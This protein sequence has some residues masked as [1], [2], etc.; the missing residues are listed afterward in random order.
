MNSTLE[1]SDAI[2]TSTVESGC[3]FATFAEACATIEGYAG[4]TNS[5]IILGKTK[6][7]PDN[8]YKQVLFVCEKQGKYAG[9]NDAYT[10]KCIGCPFAISVY[11]RKRDKEFAIIKSC[12][13]HNHDPCSDATKFS[14]VMRKLDQNDLGLIEKLHNDGLR[15]K[16]IFSV[17][18]S[19]STKYIH[20]PDVYD[21]ISRQRQ[22]KLQG[23]S[24]IEMLLKNLHEDENIIGDIALKNAFNDERNQDGKFMQAI[25]WAYRNAFSEF[26]VGKDVL[27]I[28]ATYKTNRFSMPLVAICSVD[29]FG[30]TYPL[31]FALVYS[32]TQEFY[33]WVLQQLSKALIIV[34]GS[35]QVATI[36]TDRELALMIAISKV[37]PHT[38]HQLCTW[39]IFKNIKNKLRREVEID[40]FIKDVQKLTYSD[41]SEGEAEK[42]ITALW[43]KYPRAKIYMSET[44]MPYKKSWLA[45]Y[46][47]GNIN[48]DLRSSQRVESLHS[49]LKG[50]KN[51]IIPNKHRHD[52]ANMGLE[53]LKSVCSRFAFESF[54]KQQAELAKSESYEVFESGNSAY[55]VIQICNYTNLTSKN[56]VHLGAPGFCICLHPQQTRT[57]SELNTVYPHIV[58]TFRQL[59]SYHHGAFAGLMQ[60][61]SKYVMEHGKIPELPQKGPNI[62][63]PSIFETVSISDTTNYD[64]IKMPAIKHSRGRPPNNGRIHSADE[65]KMSSKKSAGK[66]KIDDMVLK[67]IT[68]VNTA[69]NCD[70]SQVPAAKRS[71]GRPPKNAEQ[72]RF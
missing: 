28:D 53:K 45:P 58:Q 69:E 9:T 40:E 57:P 19:V 71:R 17:L 60:Q 27:I 68:C 59:L 46:T 3:T 21:A 11:Y 65:N 33:C 31:A 18:N 38:K 30:S 37:F 29:R 13:E 72:K 50:I 10:T 67:P 55:N 70:K 7:N 63:Q 52:E 35:A 39:H 14:S 22:L 62:T 25:F 41:L 56:I 32:E 48:L 44:W 23:L 12:L 51:R 66:R 64:E 6:K 24:E 26:A 2:D 36:I 4:R 1:L 20:K 16:D 54:I 47:K 8:S 5:V 49:K 15:T 61:A 34:T 43:I 42:D